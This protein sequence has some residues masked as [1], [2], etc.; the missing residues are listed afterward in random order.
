MEGQARGQ[1]LMPL[2]V[3]PLEVP[4]GQQ[5]TVAAGTGKT[6][7][8]GPSGISASL[9]LFTGRKTAEVAFSWALRSLPQAFLCQLVSSELRLRGGPAAS[10]RP[11]CFAVET[12]MTA[13]RL[14]AWSSW[15][16]WEV[17]SQCAFSLLLPGACREVF[18]ATAQ[19]S[20]P[21]SS[22]SETLLAVISLNIF[23]T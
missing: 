4:R 5:S 8:R 11:H 19:P 2:S 9:L 21:L 14:F 12:Q 7:T 16:G 1:A 20:T 6:W 13:P 23:Q 15:M 3:L 10:P 18:S 22:K 17:S